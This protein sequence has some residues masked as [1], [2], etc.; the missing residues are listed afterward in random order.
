MDFNSLLQGALIGFSIA[1]P[2]GP[3][4]ILCIQQTL[5]RGRLHG[6]ICGLGAATAD[7]VY[8]TIA[9][10]GVTVVM[11]VL[12]SQRF[13]LAV[14]GGAVLCCIGFTIFRNKNK[15]KGDQPDSR[16]RLG[17][18]ITTFGL[19]LANP[20]TIVS[21]ASVYL[22]MKLGSLG[23]LGLQSLLFVSGVFFGSALWWLI[24]SN[25]VGLVRAKYSPQKFGIV[26]RIAGAAI[27]AFGIFI[28]AS[29]FL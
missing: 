8:G 24:L 25:A 6:F 10:L 21:F 15:A 16:S 7:A 27:I 29:Q 4:G 1:A 19:T 23:D 11:S 3:I 20:L 9:A 28:I 2:V 14:I 13:W 18:Y 26:N 12:V 5:M 22:G 17:S